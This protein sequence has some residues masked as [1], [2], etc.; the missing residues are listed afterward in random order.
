MAAERQSR[1]GGRRVEIVE[2]AGDRWALEEL[3]LEADPSRAL[4]AAYL[5]EGF[6]LAALEGGRPVGE[7]LAVPCPGGW[8]LKNLAVDAA[9]RRRGI[10]RALVEGVFARLAPGETLW[11]GT[12]EGVPWGLAFY[13]ACGFV[14]DH[15]VPGFFLKNYPQPVMDGGI[16]CIDMVYL[17]RKKEES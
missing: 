3:L 10:G 1:R 17:R 14:R 16:R 8:E 15:L 4:V 11:V 12:A 9:C 6:L 2:W 7:A 5:G 13:G